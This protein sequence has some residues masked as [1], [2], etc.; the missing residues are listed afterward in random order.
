LVENDFF[1]LGGLTVGKNVNLNGGYR[2]LKTG[3][4]ST[5][6]TAYWYPREYSNAVNTD[7]TISGGP[8]ALENKTN[9]AGTGKTLLETEPNARLYKVVPT[10][11]TPYS[12]GA[13]ATGIGTSTF[14]NMNFTM[15][16]YITTATNGYQYPT[17]FNYF[18]LA[19]TTKLRYYHIY[20]VCTYQNGNNYNMYINNRNSKDMAG[21]STLLAQEMITT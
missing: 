15:F 12:S 9:I 21:Y 4:T 7:T 19:G 11:N 6:F 20:A 8:Q 3:L 16:T 10:V 1:Q 13:V 5:S 2:V 14:S 18:E 17:S